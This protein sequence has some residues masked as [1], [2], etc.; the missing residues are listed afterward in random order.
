[1]SPND[2]KQDVMYASIVQSMSVTYETEGIEA[3]ADGIKAI[4]EINRVATAEKS[5]SKLP[6]QKERIMKAPKRSIGRKIDIKMA[7]GSRKIE[8]LNSTC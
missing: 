5:S 8:I 6:N 3:L 4:Y 7:P 1:M 2:T